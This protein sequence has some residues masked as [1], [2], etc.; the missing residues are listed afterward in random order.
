MGGGYRAPA[1]DAVVDAIKGTRTRLG[2][3]ERPTGTSYVGLV[4]W[5]KQTLA[6]ITAQVNTIATNWM[7]ANAYTKTQVDNK[8]A[9]PGS[10]GPADVNASGN[11]TAGGRVISAGVVNSPGTKANTVTVGYSAVYIDSAGNMGGNT[12]SRRFKQ[13]ISVVKTDVAG[14]LGLKTYRF[15]YIDAVEELGDDAPWEFGLMAEDVVKVA[16]WACFYEDDGIT[17]RGINYD[18]LIVA[19]INVLQDH[20]ARLKAAGL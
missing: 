11:V 7:A 20:E 2:E 16:P 10:I 17:V 9:S 5:V 4:D 3:L 19:A 14:F 8:I 12:S 6:N 15:R 1:D 13:D 18:R